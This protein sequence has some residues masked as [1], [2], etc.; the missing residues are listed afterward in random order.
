[1]QNTTKFLSYINNF[2]TKNH[3]RKKIKKKILSL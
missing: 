2:E 3:K 1:M